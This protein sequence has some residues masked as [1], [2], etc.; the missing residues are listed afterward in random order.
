MASRVCCSS[1]ARA[2]TTASAA[3]AGAAGAR[4][5]ASSRAAPRAHSHRQPRRAIRCA[6]SADASAPAAA[7]ALPA[8][9]EALIASFRSVPDPMQRYKQLLYLGSKLPALPDE[10]RTDANKVKGCVSQ[11]WVLA[12]LEGGQ[13][14]LCADS[15]SAL[16]KG[17]A[18]LLVE[19]LSGAPTSEVANV[20]PGFIEELGLKQSLTP[21]RNNGFL[22]MLT[23]IQTNVAA[24]EEQAPA[25]AEGSA[26]GGQAQ[27]QA[28][29]DASQA[30]GS[31]EGSSTRP[32][33]DAIVR[34]VSEALAPERLVLE[35]DSA[36]HSGHAGV[37]GLRGEET[38]FRMEVVSAAFEGLN[39]VKRQRAVYALL[40][41]EFKGTLHALA[42]TCKTPQEAAE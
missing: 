17:L 20:T 7:A 37:N 3:S 15:D 25:A 6:A 19:G 23:L 27:V 40:G 42:L 32:V 8:R 1:R 24:L 26:A 14:Q 11:V 30:S 13:V 41:D 28:G 16:T 2:T 22:N 21:S 36:A 12:T 5:R 9:L 31:G 10:A 4:P 39:R 29:E 35:N 18:A 34:K 33:Y 38:H